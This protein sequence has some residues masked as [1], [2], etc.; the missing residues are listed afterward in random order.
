[1][2]PS[3]GLAL[4]YQQTRSTLFASLVATGVFAIT[5]GDTSAEVT[6]FAEAV[7]AALADR[8]GSPNSSIQGI[9]THTPFS[10]STGALDYISHSVVHRLQQTM[11]LQ[12]A[13]LMAR[14]QHQHT[15]LIE[16]MQRQHAELKQ[17]M[18]STT[19]LSSS[20]SG[21]RQPLEEMPVSSFD[22]SSSTLA[23]SLPP[24]SLPP[25]SSEGLSLSSKTPSQSSDTLPVMDPPA[26]SGSLAGSS[27]N[28]PLCVQLL[29]IVLT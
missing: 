19:Q 29:D 24:S 4:P 16:V 13:E 5:Y 28:A 12:H 23:P 2:F 20:L 25:S 9:S 11:Q 18:Q 10:P 26:F 21:C 8:L 3:G 17:S 27:G 1:M 15:E 6:M 7:A 14:T 22:A